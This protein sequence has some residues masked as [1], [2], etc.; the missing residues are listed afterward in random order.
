M[1][2]MPAASSARP[3]ALR[4]VG[5]TSTPLHRAV[6]VAERTWPSQRIKIGVRKP[7]SN[8]ERFDRLS[9]AYPGYF[10]WAFADGVQPLSTTNTNSVFFD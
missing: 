3:R 2:D 7:R 9:T 5:T 8:G 4:I 1:P 10:G 6:C